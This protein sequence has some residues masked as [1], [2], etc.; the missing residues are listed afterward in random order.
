MTNDQFRFNIQTIL[1]IFL[2]IGFVMTGYGQEKLSEQAKKSVTSKTGVVVCTVIDE[3]GHPLDYATVTVLNTKDSSMVNGS[4]TNSKG[5]CILSDIPW[6][7][8]IVRIG[9][10]GYKDIYID[11]VTVS[12][13]SPVANLNRQQMKLGS[14][15]IEG[16]TISAK[17]DMLQTNLDKKVFNVD[18]SIASEGVT[19]LEVLENIPSVNVDLEGNISLRGSESV[20]ILVDGRPTNLTLDQIPS[21]MIESVELITNPS[22]RFDPDGISGIINVVLKKKKESG[23]NGMI[24]LGSGINNL[25]DKF[26]WGRQ[27]A[28]AS[29]NYRY[30]KINLFANYDF[31]SRGR[32]NT[33]SM[34]RESIFNN[35]TTILNQNSLSNSR[36]YSHNVRTGMDYFINKQNTFSFNVSFNTHNNTSHSETDSKSQTGSSD[37]FDKIYKLDNERTHDSKNIGANLFYKHEFHKK[38][39][40][41]SVDIYYSHRGETTIIFPSKIIHNPPIEKIFIIP[42][43]PMPEINIQPLKL[44]S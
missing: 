43:Q 13:S 28:S 16:V 14:S 22:A 39:Q 35:D 9:Y 44:I 18:Q 2:L 37:A 1:T 15:Q 12:Q 36:G 21:S 17:K 24:T 41:L 29:I 38:G 3:T 10:I 6:G 23:F 30:N 33:G 42:K 7:K 31:R 5:A 25:N 8:Y 40:E 19:G 32:N 11:E 26:Y 4:I 20:T 27:N 34:E